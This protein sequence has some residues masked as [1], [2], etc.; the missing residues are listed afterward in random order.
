[1]NYFLIDNQKIRKVDTLDDAISW[2]L[3]E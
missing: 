3:G 1:G 2:Y